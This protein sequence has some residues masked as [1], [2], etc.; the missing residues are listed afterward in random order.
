MTQDRKSLWI[1][2]P[3]GLLALLAFAVYLSLTVYRPDRPV[4]T[5]VP[6]SSPGPAFVV[7]I[8]RPRLGLPLGGLLPPRIF[9]LE[10]HLGFDSTSAGASIGNVEPG[11]I[12]LG[13]D[14]WTVVLILDPNGQVASDSEVVFEFVFEERLQRVRCRPSDPAVGTFSTSVPAT[15]AGLSGSFDIELPHC[16]YADSGEPLGWP[17]KPLI[18]HGSFDRLP[19]SS[20]AR[21][22]PDR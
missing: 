5:I 18:L 22:A 4:A 10:S 15:S 20:G 7:Q 12:E 6:G 13:A 14:G 2:L 3:L 8:I 19:P 21:P 9:G 17:P 1:V 11:R 16:E